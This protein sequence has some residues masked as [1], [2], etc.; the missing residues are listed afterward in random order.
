[1]DV[2]HI[3]FSGQQ[4][5]EYAVG[6]KYCIPGI[7]VCVVNSSKASAAAKVASRLSKD[8]QMVV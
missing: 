8:G 6:S 1:V 5:V 2:T 4:A 7:P 3:L